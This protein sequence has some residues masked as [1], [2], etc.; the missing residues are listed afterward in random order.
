MRDLRILIT[1]IGGSNMESLIGCL[2]KSKH[3]NYYITGVD[4]FSAGNVKKIINS[5]Y[6]VPRGDDS[7]YVEKILELSLKEKV[8]FILPGSDE[9]ALSISKH[10]DLFKNL[11]ICP[12]VSKFDVLSLISNKIETYNLLAR[13][14]LKVPEYEVIDSLEAF[15]LSLT[16]YG[17][18]QN[19]VVTKPSNGRGGRGLYVFL[20][21]DEPPL[22]LGSGKR[23]IRVSKNVFSINLLRDAVKSECLVMPMLLSPAYD[24]DVMSVK[25]DVKT[26]II[27][28]RINP[29]GIPFKGNIIVKDK[30]IEKY[31]RKISKILKLDGIHDIDL[32][33]D[34]NGNACIIEVNPRP[35]GSMAASLI[36][37]VP[38]V[39]IAILSI[40]NQELPNINIKENIKV[41][42]SKN[43][44]RVAN[45][46]N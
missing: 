31:C 9:E 20:G 43:I 29:A 46:K 15:K 33:T 37:G 40:L 21:D 44:M 13:N 38:V 2:R 28:R 17:Y 16:K 41:L 34:K 12:I 18:P 8:Q 7:D 25:G 24:V 39:D 4:N 23:E 27:R 22:W 36:A 3:F 6:R 14:G 45:E 19:T 42:Q 35:S 1:C 30:T 26:I 11:G 10:N 5:F 32:M